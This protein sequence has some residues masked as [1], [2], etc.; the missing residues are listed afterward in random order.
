MQQVYGYDSFYRQFDSPLMRRFREEA[1]GEDIGQHSWVS[2]EQVRAD[3]RR[4]QLSA[5]SRLLDLGCGPCGPLTFVLAEVGCQGTGLELNDAA[6]TAGQQRAEQLQVSH[7]LT[8]HPCDLNQRL[9]LADHSFDA[10]MSLDVVL[11]LQN[12]SRFFQDVAR[13]LSPGGRFLLVDAGVISG[14]VS[15]DELNRRSTHGYNQFVPL[16]CN[17]TL[18]TAAGFRVLEIEDR[19]DSVLHHAA[20]RLKAL[21]THREEFETS[22]FTPEYFEQQERYLQT[23]IELSQR[24]ALSRLMYLANVEATS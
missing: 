10:A 2:A 6:L 16:G 7:L 24:R 17:E 8:V 20:G 23:L 21:R 18:L 9:P 14:P 19:T 4:L 11:H 1:Y 5:S 3:L 13:V 22:G 15:S 12:R